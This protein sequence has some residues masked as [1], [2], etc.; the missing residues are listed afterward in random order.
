MRLAFSVLIA[1][2]AAPPAA[3][4]QGSNVRP[5]PA[6]MTEGKC[7]AVC[8]Q[9]MWWRRHPQAARSDVCLFSLQSALRNERQGIAAYRARDTYTGGMFI[10]RRTQD[11]KSFTDCVN[12]GARRRNFNLYAQERGL[13]G[14]TDYDRPTLSA[15]FG[16]TSIGGAPLY[17]D[18]GEG[19]S[20][21]DY[22]EGD[23]SSINGLP[24]PFTR[25][26][27]QIVGADR[28]RVDW[29]IGRDGRRVNVGR[30][31]TLRTGY[32]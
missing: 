13:S 23:L 8:A 10:N 25:A 7:Q 14:G 31:V 22:I 12:A 17:I 30:T 27:G 5:D 2:L 4:S 21:G 19:H 26:S 18:L 9:E 32:R 24:S 20:I 11:L 29:V 3:S 28:F 6:W 16:Q 1:V 15:M